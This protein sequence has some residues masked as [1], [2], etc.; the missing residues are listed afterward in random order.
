MGVFDRDCPDEPL[1]LLILVK[2]RDTE[3]LQTLA[4]QAIPMLLR[5]ENFSLQ[6]RSHLANNF[7]L[8]LEGEWASD[9]QDYEPGECV[10]WEESP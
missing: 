8:A 2:G 3:R 5:P 6:E 10:D 9:K 7:R 1:P 4:Q